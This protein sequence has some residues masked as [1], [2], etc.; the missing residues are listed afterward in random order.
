[1]ALDVS[2]LLVCPGCRAPLPPPAG[3]GEG[4]R[5]CGCGRTYS[6]VRGIPRFVASEAY[7]DSFGFEWRRHQRTQLDSGSGGESE[8]TFRRKTGL[9]P[10]DLHEKL[11]LDVGCGMGR[12]AEVASRWGAKVVAVD[13]SLAVEAARENLAGRPNAAV[14]QADCFSLPFS[15][16]TFDVIYSI[17]V[18]HHTPDCRAA[19]RA[20]VPLLKRGGTIAIWVYA[21]MDRWA[22]VAGFYRNVTTRMPH[23]L[24]HAL[25][26]AAVPLYYVHRIPRLGNLTQ[27]LFPTSMHP[28]ASWR[29]LD[30]F[31]WYS[32][33]YQSLH[34]A[35]EV[36]GWFDGAGLVNVQVLDA[37]VAV[38]GTRA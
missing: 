19:F 3:W 36:R 17:G 8:R 33:R 34:T 37:P 35:E 14:L 1:M 5:R 18:L 4:E 13:L 38:R 27:I 22:T 30:T 6:R 29:V 7:A 31:D 10:E 16:G 15:Q 21:R 23:R 12:F 26:S 28:V 24:L 11:V 2:A 9:T 20:L 25:C 32:P